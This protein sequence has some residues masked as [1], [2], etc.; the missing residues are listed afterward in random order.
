MESY[1]GTAGYSENWS[2]QAAAGFLSTA[3]TLTP[4]QN[5]LPFHNNH[6]TGV[7]AIQEATG[8]QSATPDIITTTT[9]I[10]DQEFIGGHRGRPQGNL[11]PL[12]SAYHQTQHR[13]QHQLQQQLREESSTSRGRTRRRSDEY[14]HPPR[15]PIARNSSSAEEPLYPDGRGNYLPRSV[16]TG[17]APPPSPGSYLSRMAHEYGYQQ[18]PHRNQG[19]AAWVEDTRQRNYRE[20]VAAMERE[21]RIE[22]Q[23]S[24]EH[25]MRR[26]TQPLLTGWEEPTWQDHGHKSR[27]SRKHRSKKNKKKKGPCVFM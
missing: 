10:P 14:T 24:P 15:D 23:R 18:Q 21:R 17:Q 16:L 13:Q 3:I 26:S 9:T 12:P 8:S 2:L 1:K 5:F 19:V 20:Q 22:Q 11:R 6:S 27:K 25:T 7:S 4:P